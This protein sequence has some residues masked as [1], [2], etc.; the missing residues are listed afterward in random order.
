MITPKD[1]SSSLQLDEAFMLLGVR[2]G[3]FGHWMWEYLPQYI[4]ASLS[5]ALPPVP[6]L[7]DADMPR[8]HRQALEVMLPDG[9]EI[10]ELARFATARVRRLWRAARQVYVELHSGD[11]PESFKWECLGA[12]PARF[13]VILREMARR[14]HRIASPFTGC[15]R[16]FLARH[17]FRNNAL[18]NHKAIE[19]A[20]RERGFLVVYPEDLEFAEQVRVVSQAK[21]VVGPIGSSLY[22]T[23]FL[24]PGA[25]LC[26]LSNPFTLAYMT[27]LTGYLSE[28]G[29]EVVM[30]TGPFAHKNETD[31][32]H[33]PHH[34]DFQIDEKEFC[35]FLD[36]WLQTKSV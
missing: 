30:L 11:S 29:V 4:A 2:A 16:V 28:I 27:F 20:A 21:V 22:L 5:G 32:N 6:V 18:V 3:A 23:F 1:T 19:A 26:A 14:A 7:V 15:E 13:A 25:K 10:I 17:E 36:R 8:T 35:Q 9:V 24:R 33:S 31:P 12:P 34:S